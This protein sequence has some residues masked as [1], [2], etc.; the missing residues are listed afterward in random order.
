MVWLFGKNNLHDIV[1]IECAMVIAFSSKIAK[2]MK[3][4]CKWQEFSLK[5]STDKICT[6]C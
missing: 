1:V 4:F 2:N 3:I 5:V 6:F